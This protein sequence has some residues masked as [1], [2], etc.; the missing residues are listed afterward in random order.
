MAAASCGPQSQRSEPNTSHAP[1]HTARRATDHGGADPA[2]LIGIVFAVVC[3]LI[4]MIM[5]GSSPM[6]IILIP[7]LILIFGGTGDLAERKLLP[8]LYQRQKAGQ[9]SEPTRIFGASR[10]E[11]SDDEFREFARKAIAE[12]VPAELAGT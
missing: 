10:S 2:T 6:S 1:T 11:L 5:E 3:L 9:F 8:A 4:M 7:P 12:H